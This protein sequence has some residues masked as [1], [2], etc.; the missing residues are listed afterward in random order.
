MIENTL[1]EAL[2][3]EHRRHTRG[4]ALEGSSDSSQNRLQ[5]LLSFIADQNTEIGQMF[6]EKSSTTGDIKERCRSCTYN[7]RLEEA[8]KKVDHALEVVGNV[9]LR[10]EVL[11]F[12][13]LGHVECAFG[14]VKVIFQQFT[15]FLEILAHRRLFLRKTISEIVAESLE[16]LVQVDCGGTVILGSD[17]RDVTNNGQVTYVVD[18]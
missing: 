1:R 3:G 12:L 9:S 17:I 16:Q 18:R 15:T 10:D 13:I 14:M 6:R 11:V 4:E 5:D 2:T 8:K 7:G